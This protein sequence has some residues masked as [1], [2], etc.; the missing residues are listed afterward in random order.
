MKNLKL[1]ITRSQDV[2]LALLAALLILVVVNLIFFSSSFYSKV[3]LPDS[4]AGQVTLMVNAEKTRVNPDPNSDTAIILGDSRLA[5]GFSAKQASLVTRPFGLEIVNAAIP[6]TTPRCWYYFLS[7]I[8]PKKDKFNYIVMG[9][10]SLTKLTSEDLQDRILD[11]DYIAPIVSKSDIIDVANTFRTIDSKVSAF[12]MLLMPGFVYKYDVQDLFIHP[13]DRLNKIIHPYVSIG[14]SHNYDYSGRP[15]TLEGVKWDED[16]KNVVYPETYPVEK[17]DFIQTY[18]KNLEQVPN[19]TNLDYYVYWLS[20]ISERYRQ[21]NTK[22]IV[23]QLP[24]GPLPTTPK[25]ASAFPEILELKNKFKNIVILPASQ[26]ANLESPELFFDY[27]HLNSTGRS[28]LTSQ[29]TEIIL[30]EHKNSETN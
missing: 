15:E 17:R 9:L 26:F 23:F 14:W 27:L 6:S 21:T 19:G 11:L 8:D 10:P 25:D 1:F 20:R 16:R 12:R 13:K 28:K 5:E 22:I 30:S 24:S 3:F 7:K 2:L 18:V 4:A 29:L